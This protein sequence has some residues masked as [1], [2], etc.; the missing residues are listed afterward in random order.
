MTTNQSEVQFDGGVCGELFDHDFRYNVQ[1]LE[2]T[3]HGYSA[4]PSSRYAS[5]ILLYV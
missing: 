4:H 3:A 2:L 1:D 5:F